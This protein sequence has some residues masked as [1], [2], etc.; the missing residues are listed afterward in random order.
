M[1][2]RRR[3]KKGEIEWEENLKRG[4][5]KLRKWKAKGLKEIIREIKKKKK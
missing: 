4:K 1:R 2:E 3:E 5:V